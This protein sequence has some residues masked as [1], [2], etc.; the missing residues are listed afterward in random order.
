MAASGADSIYASAFSD[1]GDIGITQ[2][3]L[4]SAKQ[5]SQNGL[6]YNQLSVGKYKDMF[7]SDKALTAEERALAMKEL[8]IDYSTL[9]S[10]VAKNRHMGT[11]QMTLL[12]DGSS[13][14]GTQALSDG[15]VDSIGNVDDVRT[16]LTSKINAEAVICGID[17]D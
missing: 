6:T 2:S 12:A 5:D 9:V 14:T 4:D 16:Y 13:E 17:T 10:I 11:D 15:L 8:Q 7:S 1:V 3:Y